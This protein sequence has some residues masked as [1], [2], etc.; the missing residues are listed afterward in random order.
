MTKK[1]MVEQKVSGAD[2]VGALLVKD[3]KDWLPFVKSVC[4]A[5][6]IL[7]TAIL[8]AILMAKII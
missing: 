1:K 6:I 5:V 8:F 2:I 7:M 4:W 3:K